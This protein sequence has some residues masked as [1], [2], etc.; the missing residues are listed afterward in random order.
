MLAQSKAMRRAA[1]IGPQAAPS[2]CQTS[3]H[4]QVLLPRRRRREGFGNPREV[5]KVHGHR[6]V[7]RPEEGGTRNRGSNK[8]CSEHENAGKGT[9]HDM[10]AVEH[11]VGEAADEGGGAGAG[12]AEEVGARQVNSGV[13]KDNSERRGSG[14]GLE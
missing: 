2:H 5:Y 1:G 3:G 14:G 9:G 11:G 12:G 13:W 4:G 6:S 8:G 10:D 7:P